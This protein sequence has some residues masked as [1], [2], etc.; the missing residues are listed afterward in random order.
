MEEN[1][2]TARPSKVAPKAGEAAAR[3]EEMRSEI[4]PKREKKE[5]KK[6]TRNER[7]NEKEKHPSGWAFQAREPCKLKMRTSGVPPLVAME[8]K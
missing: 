2:L 8:A 4:G 5:R 7:Q 6:K 3:P 1:P